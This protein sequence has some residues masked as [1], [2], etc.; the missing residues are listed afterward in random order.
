MLC[1]SRIVRTVSNDEDYMDAVIALLLN[2]DNV[3]FI[4]DGDKEDEDTPILTGGI[5]KCGD[6]EDV[7]ESKLIYSESNDIDTG[8]TDDN[9]DIQIGLALTNMRCVTV[10]ADVAGIVRR[11]AGACR[12]ET[13][14]LTVAPA[15]HFTVNVYGN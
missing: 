11:M 5:W 6:C 10:R 1:N 7:D 8:M 3:D 14:T 13:V 2:G 9:V 4:E 15:Q 12:G